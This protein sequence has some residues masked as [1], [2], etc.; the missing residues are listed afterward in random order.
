MFDAQHDDLGTITA[1]L[2]ELVSSSGNKI[3]HIAILS[4]G[5]PGLLKLTPMSLFT[6]TSVQSNPAEWNTLGTLL[7]ED[8]RMDLY[9]CSL[10]Q[11]PAGIALVQTLAEAT[12]ATVWA[13]DDMTGNIAGADWDL[14]VKSATSNMASLI[15]PAS[16]DAAGLYLASTPVADSQSVAVNE[17]GTLT[18]TVTGSDTDDPDVS[19]VTFELASSVTHGT[20]SAAGS[21]IEVSAGLYSQQFLYTPTSNYSGADS[22][23]FTLKTPTDP[24]WNGFAAGVAIG[25]D[26]ASTLSAAL[27][28]VDGDG[29]LDLIAGN[30][31]QT[32]KVYLGNGDG[33]FGTGTA[34]GTDTDQTHSVALGDVDGD[35]DLDLI[36]GNVGQT[37]KV[38]LG[39]GDGTFGTGTAIGTDTDYTRSVALGDLD[40]DGDLDVVTGN[41][42]QTNKVYLGNG[43]GTFGTG[44]AIGTD[45]DDTR[46]IALGDVDGDGDLDVI[47]GNYA[48]TNKV[49]L[50]NGA[51]GFSSGVAIG[52][53]TDNT[54]SIALGDVDGDGDLDV[55]AGNY[56]QTNKVYLGNGNG[57]FGSG[58]AIG[59]DTDSTTSVAL[60]DVD[61][62]GDLDVIA[63]NYSQTNKVYL[64]NGNGTF[65]SGTAIGT[66]TDSTTS[67]AL[68]DVDGDGDLDVIAGNY[69]QTNK[70]YLNNG[71]DYGTA[72]QEFRT[73]S[74]LGSETDHSSSVTF[75]DMDSDGDLDMVVGNTSETSKWYV[76]DGNGLFTLGGNISASAET[77]LSIAVGD[78]DKD[79]DLD[80]VLGN[81]GQPNRVYV[82]NGAGVFSYLSEFSSSYGVM[83]IKLGDVDRDGDID[84]VYVSSQGASTNARVYL[85]DGTG[86]FSLGST[87]ASGGGYMLGLDLGDVNNDGWLDVVI[88]QDGKNFG[89]PSS[90]VYLNNH[91]GGFTFNANIGPSND[92]TDSIALGDVNGDGNL[93]F[94]TGNHRQSQGNKVYLGNGL[95]GFTYFRTIEVGYQTLSVTLG[96]LDKDGDLDLVTGVQDQSNR[97]YLNNG[98]GVFT[99]A[100]GMGLASD[101]T[102]SLALADVDNDGDLDVVE[103]NNGYV[104]TVYQKRLLRIVDRGYG[105]HHGQLGER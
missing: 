97:I 102:S 58:T 17:D 85:N 72:L 50:G 14:E 87:F 19:M 45:T 73:S 52:T 90:K 57:T 96:D 61:G 46:S 55:I 63:G 32:N 38:Y 12:G 95:G 40:G 81:V 88:G 18:I 64:G 9:A 48:Q 13:S 104:N 60:G 22:F 105:E 98:A 41:Y 6:A 28:D 77:T 29:D 62:D 93:D 16:V 79:G 25:T 59:T 47:A 83:E 82:N 92:I 5:D 24:V 78:V 68:G 42:A 67:V 37:N 86:V 15:D 56:S 1:Q 51:G 84:A 31:G 70:V 89:T 75:G 33:T 94:V 53:D 7:S 71:L 66:D 35:G 91:S 4:H 2:S 80:V 8:A 76:N 99:F 69:S 27:G 26:T 34:I 10:G 43:D 100:A 101:N 21:V 20:L 36:A 3:D 49:Y 103:A 54:R 39:N 65:G 44:T 11:G 30:V 74:N 23:Q